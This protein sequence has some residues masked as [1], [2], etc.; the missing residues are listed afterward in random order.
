MSE[1]FEW[2][3]AVTSGTPP[4]PREGHTAVAIENK[5]YF[6]GGGDGAFPL[7]ETYVLDTGL[8]HQI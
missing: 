5:I 4:G 8:K 2:K 6:F 1:T 7:N 3:K